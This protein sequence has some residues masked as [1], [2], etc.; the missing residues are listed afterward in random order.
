MLLQRA[1]ILELNP[2]REEY[3]R[4]PVLN[5]VQTFAIGPSRA[6]QRLC[7][8][9]HAGSLDRF[10]A[11]QIIGDVGDGLSLLEIHYARPLV[12]MDGLSRTRRD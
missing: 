10:S 12:N 1:T 3:L 8:N 11:D 2:Q 5:G 9:V 4:S 7:G 6:G